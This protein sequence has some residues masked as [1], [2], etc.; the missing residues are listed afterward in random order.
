MSWRQI[1]TM[2]SLSDRRGMRVYVDTCV[3]HRPFDG[4]SDQRVVLEADALI[5]L[6]DKIQSNEVM[7]VSSEVLE[8]EVLRGNWQDE[9][10]I[11]EEGL[12][13]AAVVVPLDEAIR[14]RASEFG[15]VGVSAMDSLHLACAEVGAADFFVTCDNRLLR[16]SSR[17]SDLRTRVIGPLAMLEFVK[18]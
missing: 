14:R 18:R 12:A 15:A 2:E 3:W 17:C 8:F 13:L 5:T 4:R 1:A 10:V 16:R 7:L 11:I 6:L 9:R